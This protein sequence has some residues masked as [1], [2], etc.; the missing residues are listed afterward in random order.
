MVR[1]LSGLSIALVSALC[2]SGC[3]LFLPYVHPSAGAR[4]DASLADAIAYAN[5]AKNEYMKAQN[6]Y[7]GT[8]TIIPYIAIPLAAA[9]LGLA[10]T[11]T[12]GAPVTALGLAA[13]TGVAGGAWIQ[14][15]PREMAY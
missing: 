13:G 10:I 6:A 15:K 14:N 5:D 11:G 12:T 3:A 2:L 8:A 7:A 9:S 4:R 1:W